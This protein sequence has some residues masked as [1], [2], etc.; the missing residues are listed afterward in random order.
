V[1]FQP[2]QMRFEIIILP[3][4]SKTSIK[5]PVLRLQLIESKRQKIKMMSGDFKR[6]KG[7]ETLVWDYVTD[8]SLIAFTPS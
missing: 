5:L 7:L 3:P 6:S 8:L 2:I 1:W 4:V